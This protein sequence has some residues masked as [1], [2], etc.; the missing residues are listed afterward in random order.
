MSRMFD[1]LL[2]DTFYIQA[3]LN[4]KDQFHAKALELYPHVRQ[5]RIVWITEA[6]L[7]EIG[8]ALSSID[9]IAAASF[10]SSCYENPPPNLRIVTVDAD[11]M[12]LALA[13]YSNR[14]DKEWG[15]TDCISFEVM[16]IY[17]VTDALTGD[18][19]FTQAGFNAL[20]A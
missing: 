11:L 3:L 4:S 12:N 10:I 20:M 13:F 16:R 2:L 18:K 6:V 1:Q 15:F 19:H 8:N 7:V 14:P 17:N 5:A 9:R